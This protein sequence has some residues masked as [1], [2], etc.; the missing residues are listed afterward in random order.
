MRAAV[1]NHLDKIMKL[2]YFAMLRDIAGKKEE[3]WLQPAATLG[4]LIA[5]LGKRYGPDFEKWL[6]H[7][8][9]MSGMAM[10][11]VNGRDAR[12][13]QHFDTPLHPDDEIVIIPPVAGG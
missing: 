7:G 1:S 5:S 3:Q 8:G 2:L 6:S 13:L 9:C 4:E 12:Q 11:L 10:I